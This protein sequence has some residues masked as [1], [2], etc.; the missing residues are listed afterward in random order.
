MFL[1]VEICFH[2]KKNQ[3]LENINVGFQKDEKAF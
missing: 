1:L 2:A 3:H